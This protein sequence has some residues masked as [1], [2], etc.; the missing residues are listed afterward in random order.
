MKNQG[1]ALLYKEN[2]FCRFRQ[3]WAKALLLGA[4][5]ALLPVEHGL[6]ATT[7]TG[8]A[9]LIT[10]Q[11]SGVSCSWGDAYSANNSS[12]CTGGA[13]GLNTYYSYWIEVPP[14]TSEL[15]VDIFDADIGGGANHDVSRS[16]YNTAV[17]YTLHNPTGAIHP[18][19]DATLFA[20]WC[21]WCD[22]N[23]A[24]WSASPVLN[25]AP[26]YWEFRVDQSSAVTTGND[27]NR[28]GVRAY[29]PS[30]DTSLN[31]FYY[32]NNM[33]PSTSGG[34]QTTTNY[35][36][37]TSGCFVG[38]QNFDFD[39]NGSLSLTTRQGNALS[40]FALSGNGNWQNDTRIFESSDDSAEDYGV[41]TA[42]I[43][44]TAGAN[45]GNWLFYPEAGGSAAPPASR[46]A[47]NDGRAFR[48]YLGTG[49]TG[50]P[51]GAPV[52]PYL[53]QWVRQNDAASNEFTVTVRLV[54]PTAFAITGAV[55][56][57]EIP[58]PVTYGGVRVAFPTHGSMTSA[59]GVGGSG[60]FTWSIGTVAAG[61]TAVMAYNITVPDP[62]VVT[63][64]TADANSVNA[65]R[66][67][68]TDE[69][70]T[71]FT[72][73]GL[74]ELR[75]GP[76][77]TQAVVTDF[78]ATAHADGALL[79][80]RTAS[81]VGTLGFYVERESSGSW[82]RL[83][84]GELVPGLGLTDPQGGA[85]TYLDDEAPAAETLLYRL[86][87][88]E[89]KGN[90]RIYGPYEVALE[91]D[92]GLIQESV[93]LPPYTVTAKKA[94]AAVEVM[95]V[96][97]QS[98]GMA[99]APLGS[100]DGIR[101][102]TRET[103]LYYLSA[104]E[105]A[106]RLN[107]TEASVHTYIGQHQLILQSGGNEIAWLPADNGAGL[108]FYAEAID[109][110]YTQDNVVLLKI[111][112][113]TVMAAEDGGN[114]AAPGPP[115]TFVSEQH[116]EQ[117]KKPVLV[118]AVRDYWFW[119]QL[120]N[121]IDNSVSPPIDYR[122]AEYVFQLHAVA[123]GAAELVLELEGYSETEHAV[124]VQ[125]NGAD[126]GSLKWDGQLAHTARLALP[127]AVLK[128]GDNTLVL[129]HSGVPNSWVY[130]N[131]FDIR[132][133]RRLVA[134]DGALRF[135]IG[136]DTVA[137]IDGLG[138]AAV[139]VLR[140]DNP[141][142]PVLMD[143]ISLEA[144]GN[145]YQAS[146]VTGGEGRF[147]LVEDGAVKAPVWLQGYAEPQLNT[148][149]NQADYLVIAP[150]ELQSGA[151]A[152]AD[153]RA[154]SGL[155][156]RV[157]TL[158][159]VYLAFNHGIE[160]PTAIQHFVNYARDHWLV[161]PRY[162]LLAGDSSYDHRR[163]LG[164][165]RDDHKVPAI[166]AGTPDGMF[167]ADNLYGAMLGNAPRVAVG[168][169]P[170]RTNAELLAYLAKLQA[171]E[172]A[173]VVDQLVQLVTDDADASAGDFPADSN[174]TLKPEVPAMLLATQDIHLDAAD[175]G[176]AHDDL[177]AAL[178]DGRGL[179]NYLGHGGID[180]LAEEGM[181]TSAHVP[182]LANAQTPVMTALSCVVNR[183]ALAGVDS[184][185]EQLVVGTDAGMVA[186]W[187]PTGLSQNASAVDLNRALLQA[188][189]D[190]GHPVLGDA[191]VAALQTY[192]PSSEVNYMP[193][194]YTLLGDPAV[195]IRPGVVKSQRITNADSNQSNDLAG[196]EVG[197]GGATQCVGR[198]VKLSD[199]IID[200]DREC[201]ALSY[202]EAEN[203]ELEAGTNVRFCAPGIELKSGFRVRGDFRAGPGACVMSLR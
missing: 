48:S 12:G 117:D 135:H 127:S 68:F 17:R 22:D 183:H 153:Y 84:Q 66:A 94:A 74:C 38:Q 150:A 138:S 73:G 157:V 63:T 104:A 107:M 134:Q 62:N 78:G 9:D 146:F 14:G 1:S 60:T 27:V 124:D 16:G 61:E 173:L 179:V 36:Y 4:V 88:L 154:T 130:F 136:T 192:A 21:S 25:P 103:G 119:G 31:I 158:E 140:I 57:G 185:G 89:S 97:N 116:F 83:N 54:N 23:W 142:R 99:K 143:N 81:E 53:A 56:D 180:R 11:G 10:I 37:V 148:P 194:V 122:Q 43:S 13:A 98:P 105:V 129:T 132:Y 181:L 15:Q 201:A 159:E 28:L 123:G 33:G 67:S 96:A 167:A 155:I 100:M 52:K 42:N 165:V 147:V 121:F 71:P 164:E 126:I 177:L 8:P 7:G 184:L 30:S 152:L 87:E 80:W 69:T 145:G 45:Y 197:A 200:Q 110:I 139:R 203:T 50:N 144:S 95:P 65:T 151:Q 168:R 196:G 111:G 3:F 41:W 190:T 112:S 113:G 86:V 137:T 59:P 188:V 39:S 149:D 46:F 160:D 178:N 72:T 199:E 195:R 162:L 125:L 115:A 106:T 34:T 186:M 176:K 79:H 93:A 70:T 133:P 189:Y 85:Y 175:P 20:G 108:Y 90:P 5:L 172:S 76:T 2:P 75:I 51:G 170:V 174:N 49:T 120:A 187:A 26:G 102:G 156:T 92:G 171:W 29:D 18:G 161:A 44:L 47:L 101:I 182:A 82:E 198:R 32:T 191:I 193:K 131:S 118:R 77:L 202:L 128:E 40:A 91:T 35:P 141:G 114:P 64:V 166:F 24:S 19:F 6:A 58:S 55:V 109:S 169:I 163:L